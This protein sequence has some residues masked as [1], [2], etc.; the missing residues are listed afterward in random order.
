M[1]DGW[2]EIFYPL[3]KGGFEMHANNQVLGTSTTEER[4]TPNEKGTQPPY[5]TSWGAYEEAL[6][7]LLDVNPRGR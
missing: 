4:F 2:K 1:Y 7:V 3:R 5:M 6:F